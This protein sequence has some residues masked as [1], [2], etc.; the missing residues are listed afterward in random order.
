MIL[1]NVAIF[2]GDDLHYINSTNLKISNQCFEKIG[3][4]IKP[5]NPNELIFDCDGFVVIPGF[6]NAHIHIADS[7][8]KDVNLDLGPNEKINPIYG[9]KKKILDN[10]IPSHIASY[11]K[12]TC[13][14]MIKKGITTFV[15]FREGGIPGI[16]LLKDTISSL[17][18]RSIILGRVEYYQNSEQI[19]KNSLMQCEK[20][21]KLSL[22]AEICDGIGISGANEYSDLTLKHFSMI[23]KIRAIH[24][25]ET[26]ESINISKH[27]TG[28]SEVIRSLQLKPHFLVHMTCATKN[29]LYIARKKTN[30]IVVCP[31]ANAALAEGIPDVYSMIKLGYCISIGTDNVMVNQPDIFREMDYLWKTMMAT[32]KKR[33]DPKI[34]LKMAT[35]NAGKLLKKKIGVIKTGKFA[36]CIFIDKHSIDI[37]PMHNPYAAI[38]HRASESIIKAVMIG[39]KIVYGKI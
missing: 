11:I 24:S 20:S 14:S 16:L 23:N 13:Y 33:V 10:S 36:D 9:T 28:K 31:R 6:I 39:G 27:I 29:D 35:V 15:D 17:P 3:N 18:I 12:N 38:V 26:I 1:K 2:Y 21:K 4:N 22:I 30:G 34:I 19:K 5:Y 8:A 37:D 25:G 32:N 7:I